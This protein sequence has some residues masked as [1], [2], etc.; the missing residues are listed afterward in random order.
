M[1]KIKN[2]I[3]SKSF[4]LIIL[5]IV[6]IVLRLYKINNPIADWHSFRQADTASVTREYLNK[7]LDL[8][9]PTY[10]DISTTQSGLFNPNGY[11]FVE[12]PI[13]N[14]L[15]LELVK[16]LPWYSLEISGRF[17]SI[18]SSLASMFVIY[19]LGKRFISSWGGIIASVLFTLM[20]YNVYFTRVILPEPLAVF[21]ALMG[22]WLFVEYL[23]KEN[24]YYIYI[25]ALFYALALLVKPH[26]F[27]YLIP[28][29]YLLF[30]KYKTIGRI[31]KN[32]HLYLWVLMFIVP[33]VLWRIWI[34]QFP[35]GIPAWKWILNGD[36]IRFK[37]AFWKW[38]FAERL[39]VMILGAWGIIPFGYSLMMKGEERNF[40]RSLLLGVFI[41]VSLFATANVRH[42]YYQTIVIP[43]I[44]LAT[45]DGLISIWSSDHLHKI[46]RKALVLFTLFMILIPTWVNIKEF[47]KIN[48]PEI[49]EAG[50][51]LDQ[52]AE[53][54]A[55]V[56]APYNGDTAFLYQTKRSGW[57]VVDR[58]INELIDKGADYFVSV[59]MS[60]YQTIEFQKEYKIL[61]KTDKYIIL[62]LN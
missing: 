36:G 49:V 61:E 15:H 10:Q 30:N 48:R 6:F 9:H 14:V 23:D 55:L 31:I 62:K 17:V 45:A 16:L 1:N 39:G 18:L 46:L 34:S 29:I 58:P 25:S 3:F 27:F 12:F 28:V 21:F 40:I 32:K 54:D 2:I 50:K 59:D 53:K 57:P 56:I 11:R 38:L 20:P 5:S 51:A 26:I 19:L 4:I 24:T 43:A 44:I 33:F 35:E 47:Y 8:L 60:H 37:P 42:D 52:I 13:Y 22:L 41:Y 7:G